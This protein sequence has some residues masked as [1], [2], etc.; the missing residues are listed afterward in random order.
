MCC[1]RVYLHTG[2][3]LCAGAEPGYGG[4]LHMGSLLYISEDDGEA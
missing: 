1:D 3:S 2:L 4:G